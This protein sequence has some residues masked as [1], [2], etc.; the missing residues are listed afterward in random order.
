MLSLSW[1]ISL[2][3][4]A[5]SFSA[6]ACTRVRRTASGLFVSAAVPIGS[7]KQKRAAIQSE[8]QKLRLRRMQRLLLGVV[9]CPKRVSA[10]GVVELI[11]GEATRHRAPCQT[12][13]APPSC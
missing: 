4:V 11:S 8:A 10:R 6:L 5:R 7:K 12:L 9:S 3:M 1:A 13:F 2:E